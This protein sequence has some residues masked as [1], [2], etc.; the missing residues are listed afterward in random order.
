MALENS[1]YLWL[2]LLLPFFS[3]T[4]Y[5]PSKVQM[6]GYTDLRGMVKKFP[7]L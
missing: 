2:L 4:Q 7:L 1:H 6:P 5:T 3:F